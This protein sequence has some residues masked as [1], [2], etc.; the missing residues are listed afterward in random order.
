MNK[1]VL[2]LLAGIIVVIA[3]V[4]GVTQLTGNHQSKDETITK[5]TFT[6][7]LEG[8]Y[9]PFSYHDDSGKLVGYEV[10]MAKDIADKLGLKVKFVQT[11]WDSLIAGINSNRY[12][13]VI[14]NIGIRPDR[15]KNYRM[16]TPYLYSNSVLI[17]RT[18]ET[19]LKSLDDIKGKTMAQSL[20]SNYGQVAQQKGADIKAVAG[21]VEAMNLITTNRADGSLNDQ[22]AFAAWKKA[23]PN[24]DVTTVNI[25]K[26][27]KSVPT[28]VL[29]NKKDEQLQKDVNKAIK[30]LKKDGTLTKL[31]K[32]YF[33]VD[34]SH[35]Q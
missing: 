3:G 34:L 5:G 1:K 29:M 27:I 10:D 6:V 7:G 14:N 23:N 18:D 26:D 24:A 28:G 4:V 33:G 20:T 12:D 22:G 9:A 25:S 19:D 2:I 15:E 21:I 17:K 8:T 32:K 13:A 11:K 16:S 30:E 31:S 35:E